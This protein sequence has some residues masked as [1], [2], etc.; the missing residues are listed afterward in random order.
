MRRKYSDQDRIKS[1]QVRLANA[2]AHPTPDYPLER[3]PGQIIHVINRQIL[4]VDLIPKGRCVQHLARFPDGTEILAGL[5]GIH[6]EIRKRM[7][8]LLG[9][10]NL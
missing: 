3:V 9:W 4:I 8:P 1:A 10:R 7:P 2:L 6:A 5:N